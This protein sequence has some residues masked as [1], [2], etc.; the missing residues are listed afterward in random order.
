MKPPARSL[1]CS[2]VKKAWD[3]VPRSIVKDSFVSCAITTAVDGSNDDA[4]HCFKPGQ[5]CEEGRSV[6]AEKMLAFTTVTIGNDDDSDD[7]FSS[8][9]EDDHE[10]TE[11]N[12]V[13]IDEED[14]INDD[15]D[16]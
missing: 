11:M 7:P 2:W 5:P 13:L 4:I 8:D 1:L 16:D 10:E 3:L 12:E 15:L 6:L 9:D 14:M